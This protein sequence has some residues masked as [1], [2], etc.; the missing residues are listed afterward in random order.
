VASWA[1]VSLMVAAA[2]VAARPAA[3]ATV[4]VRPP[5]DTVAPVAVPPATATARAT[6]AAASLVS[7][8]PAQLH[9]GSGD[10]FLPRPALTSAGWQYVPY[11]RTYRGLPV[12]GGDFVVVVDPAGEVSSTSVAQLAPIDNL[13]IR[14]KVTQAAAERTASAQ[15]TAVSAIKGSRLV[16]DATGDAA[17]LAWESVIAGRDRDGAREVTVEVDAVAGTVLRTKD[18][19]IRDIGHAGLN[20][21]VVNVADTLINCPIPGECPNQ[22]TWILAYPSGG[23]LSCDAP[24]VHRT[25]P[26]PLEWGNGDPTNAETACVDAMFDVDTENAMLSHWLGRN[27]LDGQGAN[28]GFAMFTDSSLVDNS[29]YV[30]GGFFNQPEVHIGHGTNG[31]WWASLDVVGHEN[32]HGIDDHTP[33]GISGGGTAEFIADA[34]GVA[35]EWYANERAPYDTPDYVLGDTAAMALPTDFKRFMYNPQ[36]AFGNVNCYSASVPGLDPHAAAGVGDHW[37]YLAAEG[38]NP[39]DGQPASPTCNGATVAGAGIQRA[40]Q[41]LYHA[42][43]MKNSASSYP[44]YRLWTLKAAHN[45]FPDDCATFRAVRGAWDAVSVPAQPGEP[46]EPLSCQPHVTVPFVIGLDPD[47][48]TATLAAAGLFASVRYVPTD[49]NQ[50]AVVSTENPNWGVSIPVN[51]TVSLT[52]PLYTPP[53][54]SPQIARTHRPNV[55]TPC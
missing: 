5:A 34:F 50:D 6:A 17:R 14:P 48:A 41:I 2:T 16:V 27:G 10:A 18:D 31:V 52:V 32:G 12:V 46:F 9:A 21:G 49:V 40:M 53:C 1:A 28:D 45:L 36:L 22:H 7:G 39:T 19:L 20:G 54:G 44:N 15:L 24:A 4:A 25:D 47:T 23:G 30:A 26:E 38:S 8:R 37:L 13:D 43:L 29:Y 42:M 51:S 35:T 11:E 33:G 3:A 55:I